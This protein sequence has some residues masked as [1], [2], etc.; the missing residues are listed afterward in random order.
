M[1]AFVI[2]T[3][4][5]VISLTIAFF[6]AV[7]NMQFLL[8]GDFMNRAKTNAMMHS[9]TWGQLQYRTYRLT[10][11]NTNVTIQTD[12]IRKSGNETYNRVESNI[13]LDTA[14]NSLNSTVQIL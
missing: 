12:Y 1:I 2:C 13:S 11:A 6:F 14:T 5:T 8:E 4:L 3:F 7:A 9:F 10:T